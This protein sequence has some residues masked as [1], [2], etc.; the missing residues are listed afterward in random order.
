[1]KTRLC[2]ALLLSFACYT[3]PNGLRCLAGVKEPTGGLVDMLLTP[4]ELG[5]ASARRIRLLIDPRVS[6]TAYYPSKDDLPGSPDKAIDPVD[7]A[8][9][10]KREL[11]RTGAE[12]VVY[13]AD[14]LTNGCYY[15][16]ILRFSAPEK[17]DAYWL[18]RRHNGELPLVGVP[19]AGNVVF[20]EPGQEL[21]PGLKARM[22]TVECAAGKYVVRLA[23]AQTGR[24]NPGL[25]LL[26]KQMEK[27]N[28]SGEVGAANRSQP[29][30]PQANRTPAA[31]GSN[32]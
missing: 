7:P 9:P 11:E 16:K 8:S 14:C 24:H 10:F 17:A 26:I 22:R 19:G 28:G 30:A 31:A 25:D 32:R 29:V 3:W 13:L 12:A 20:T 1:M 5:A 4:A 21:R 27:I 23:P 18:N 2:L 15:L 6:P